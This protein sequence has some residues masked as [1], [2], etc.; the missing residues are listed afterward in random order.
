MRSTI[1]LHTHTSASDGLLT[2]G[3]LAEAALEAGVTTLAVCDHDTAAGARMAPMTS[4]ASTRSS[5]A[6]HLSRISRMA[7]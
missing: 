1:D 5:T 4:P 2:P 7:V 6:G 3:E